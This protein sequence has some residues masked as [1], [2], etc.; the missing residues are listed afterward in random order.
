MATDESET[1]KRAAKFWNEGIPLEAGKL[2]FER[3]PN[4]V[5]PNWGSR[6]LRLVL[7]KSGVHDPLFDQVIHTA[8]HESAWGNGHRVFSNV[9]ALTLKLDA[10]RR[11]KGLAADQEQL[12]SIVALAELVAKVS[13]NATNPLD[14]FDR[15]SGWWIASSLRAFVVHWKDDEFSKEAWTAL[16]SEE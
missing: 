12:A 6:I 14:E 13:Y 8:E 4:K 7:K 16:C 2:I 11:T 1:L 15:D 3:L 10:L 9:R 5:R